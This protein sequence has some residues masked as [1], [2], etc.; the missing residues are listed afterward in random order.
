MFVRLKIRQPVALLVETLAK[1]HENSAAW[2]INA[3]F[4]VEESG[5]GDRIC[6]LEPCMKIIFSVISQKSAH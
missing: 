3:G 2:R 5:A 1:R 4:A 6:A